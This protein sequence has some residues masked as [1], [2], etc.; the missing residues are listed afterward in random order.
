MIYQNILTNIRIYKNIY[1]SQKYTITTITPNNM[2]HRTIFFIPFYFRFG[3]N[4]LQN[5]EKYFH[6]KDISTQKYLNTRKHEPRIQCDHYCQNFFLMNDDTIILVYQWSILGV[7]DRTIALLPIKSIK[8]FYVIKS[9][10]YITLIITF[11][12]FTSRY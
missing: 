1:C 10:K 8:W 3:H 7:I 12:K 5:C 11:F 6:E 2:K 4:S 9:L